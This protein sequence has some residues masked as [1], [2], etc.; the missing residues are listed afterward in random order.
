MIGSIATVCLA[1]LTA[2]AVAVAA[3][4][5]SALQRSEKPDPDPERR[6]GLRAGSGLLSGAPDRCVYPTCHHDLVRPRSG[7]ASCRRRHRRGPWQ[8]GIVADPLCSSDGALP[9]GQSSGPLLGAGRRRSSGTRSVRSLAAGPAAVTDV[10]PKKLAMPAAL[11][12]TTI[13]RAKTITPPR[14]R[15]PAKPMSHSLGCSSTTTVRPSTTSRQPRTGRPSK[16]DVCIAGLAVVT[17]SGWR[18]T[19]RGCA[20]ACRAGAARPG[21]A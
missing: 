16:P 1:F 6:Q 10:G 11:G 14:A 12:S 18:R 8:N 19:A 3:G 5:G 9:V 2:I 13:G 7:R 20:P 21:R 17:G 15:K 4:R